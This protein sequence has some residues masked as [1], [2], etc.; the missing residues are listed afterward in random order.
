MFQFYPN[1]TNARE[2]GVYMIT[3]SGHFQY[4]AELDEFYD[5]EGYGNWRLDNERGKFLDSGY[6]CYMGE[7]PLESLFIEPEG[8]QDSSMGGMNMT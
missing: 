6:I 5:F 2:Y 7:A 8:T 3:E 4:D 1:V